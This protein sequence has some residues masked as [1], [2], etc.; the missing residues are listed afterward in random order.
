[1]SAP[2]QPPTFEEIFGSDHPDID[3]IRSVDRFFRDDE[4]EGE[5]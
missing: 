3:A 5:E 1:M 4:E 2:K